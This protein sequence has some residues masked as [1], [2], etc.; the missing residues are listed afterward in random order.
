MLGVA[1]DLPEASKEEVSASVVM[2]ETDGIV[3]TFFDGDGKEVVFEVEAGKLIRYIN[4]HTCAGQHDTTGIVTELWY[5]S[6]KPTYRLGNCDVPTEIAEKLKK[7]ASTLC[8][9]NNL[10]EEAHNQS[11]EALSPRETTICDVDDAEWTTHYRMHLSLAAKNTSGNSAKSVDAQDDDFTD[12]VIESSSAWRL[13]LIGHTIQS[14]RKAIAIS[15]IIHRGFDDNGQAKGGPDLPSAEKSTKTVQGTDSANLK[16]SP[17]QASIRNEEIQEEESIKKYWVTYN[18]Y[19]ELFAPERDDKPGKHEKTLPVQE[20]ALKMAYQVMPNW[21][22]VSLALWREQP[23]PKM[24]KHMPPVTRTERYVT[25][26]TAINTGFF[27]MTFLFRA[28]CGMEPK[29]QTC[30]KKKR[31]ILIR[32]FEPSWSILASVAFGLV[33]SLPVPLLLLTCFRKTPVLEQM[34]DKEKQHRVHQFRFFQTLGWLFVIVANAF[35]VYWFSAFT[36]NFQHPVLVKVF[37][38][39]VQSLFHRLVTAPCIRGAGFAVILL[40]SKI[41]PCCDFV[42]VLCPQIILPGKLHSFDPGEIDYAIGD[43]HGAELSHDMSGFGE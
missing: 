27:V 14:L 30:E 3:A 2:P 13:Y 8:V 24:L 26:C 37:L 12:L 32:M 19:L 16:S 18:R 10:A 34:T 29:P 9:A 28:E 25:L 22:V 42:L 15:A 39:A 41:G 33:C 6:G 17:S 36:N 35:Y 20:V 11:A 7:A 1:N 40:L 31:S 5:T 38:S 4:G 43:I 21:K 23:W